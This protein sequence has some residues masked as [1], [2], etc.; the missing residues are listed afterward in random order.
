MPTLAYR[1]EYEGLSLAISS[2]TGFCQSIVNLAT[3]ADYLLVHCWDL[4]EKMRPA[5]AGMIAGT[6]QAAEIAQKAGVRHL[7]LSHLSPL[8]DL[9]DNRQKA[10]DDVAG[11]FEGDVEFAEELS[12]LRI[13]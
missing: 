3:G 5:E 10:I 9:P 8:L 7:V 12:T 6:L 1:F 11:V 2:D 4:Q 13:E